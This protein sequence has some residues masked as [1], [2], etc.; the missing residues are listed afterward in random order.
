M[1]YKNSICL[2][3][4]INLFSCSKKSDSPSPVSEGNNNWVVITSSDNHFI[5]TTI[6]GQAYSAQEKKDG[7]VSNVIGYSQKMSVTN[8][9]MTYQSSLKP[10]TSYPYFQMYVN[11]ITSDDGKDLDSMMVH[12]GGLDSLL[13]LGRPKLNFRYFK[14]TT[15]SFAPK[16]VDSTS[17]KIL[18]VKDMG[19]YLID[20]PFAG[21]TSKVKSLLLIGKI[22]SLKLYEKDKFG[23]FVTKGQV[24]ELKATEFSFRFVS[25]EVIP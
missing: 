8:Y 2:F 23:D 4:L 7:F 17:I 5:K 21:G 12:F 1:I 14:S 22:N 25:V 19:Q 24:I 20:N 16:D 11:E 9:R 13:E 10:Y 3:I 18:Q 15:Q 6:D